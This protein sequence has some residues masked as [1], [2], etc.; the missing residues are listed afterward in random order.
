MHFTSHTIAIEGVEARPVEVQCQLSRGPYSFQIVGLPGAAIREARERI[1]A[2]FYA[3]SLS[4]P[5]MRITVNLAPADL[6]KMG[7]HYDLPMAVALLCNMDLLPKNKME[8]MILLGGLALDGR[9]EKVHGVLAAAFYADQNDMG[10]VC[11]HENSQEAALLPDLPIIAPKRLIDLVKHFR[12]R[13]IPLVEKQTHNQPPNRH[14]DLSEIKGLKRQKRALEISATGR[15][16]MFMVGPP[17]AGKSLL[18]SALPSILPRMTPTEILETTL[19]HSTAGILEDANAV[20][21]R[22]FYDPHHSASAAA[23]VGGGRDANPGEISL[24]HNGVLFMDELPE[25]RR[26]VLESLRQP[27]ET[28]RILVSRANAHYSYPAKFLLIAAANPCS[29]GW[30]FDPKKWCNRAPECGQR[31]MER[32]SG[33]LLDRFTLRM[34]VEALT[35]EDIENTTPAEDSATVRA[36]V[37]EARQRSFSRNGEGVCNEDLSS[38]RLDHAL[39]LAKDQSGPLATQAMDRF[40]LSTRG[41]YRLIKTALTIADLAHAP[42]LCEDYIAEAVLYRIMEQDPSTFNLQKAIARAEAAQQ[43]AFCATEDKPQP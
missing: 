43:K 13:P 11:P 42:Q 21:E 28:S 27:L 10:L 31:Y 26:E 38:D 6:P 7:A 12:G 25:F 37:N 35:L 33:P 16:H 14:R 15:H 40:S 19:V 22:P 3:H 17:G 9:V 36:R 34:S 29:C 41:Y 2:A 1:L 5:P 4:L 8:N 18:A 20:V 24:A 32:L 23:I 30:M 39:S